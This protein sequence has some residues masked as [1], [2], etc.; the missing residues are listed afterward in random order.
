MTLKETKKTFWKSLE[1]GSLNIAAVEQFSVVERREHLY[2]VF[3][4]ELLFN[5]GLYSVKS[6][7]HLSVGF[8][9]GN[10]ALRSFPSVLCSD[11]DS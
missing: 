1:K 11:S 4:L 8:G 5:A 7:Q 2:V 9:A 10:T 3:C 6:K